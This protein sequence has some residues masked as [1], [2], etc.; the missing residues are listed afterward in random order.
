MSEYLV[1]LYLPS[2]AAGTFAALTAAARAA[3]AA[4]TADG[5][6]RY[7]RSIFVPRD[8]TC[9]FLFDADSE[10]AVEEVSRRAGLDYLRITAAVSSDAVAAPCT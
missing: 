6:V 3:V 4:P 10:A 1:E 8:E 2:G 7:L 9:F 5:A